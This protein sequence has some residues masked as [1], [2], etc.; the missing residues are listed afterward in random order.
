MKK[1]TFHL[2]KLLSYKDQMLNSEIMTLGILQNQL[3]DARRKVL[4]LEDQLVQCR[5]NFQ[6]E[7]TGK[8]TPAA[9]QLHL[10]YIEHLKHLIKQGQREVDCLT[11]KV[12]RQIET[13]KELKL[14]SKSLETIKDSRFEE[15]KK[16]GQK[17]YEAQIEEFVVTSKI[18]STTLGES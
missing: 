4:A 18:M 3:E 9:C 12:D 8:V 5:I 11:E 1:F 10:S 7:M 14:D 15:Y 17:K 6:E 13:V 2:E 16:E